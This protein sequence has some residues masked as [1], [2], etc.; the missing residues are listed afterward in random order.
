MRSFLTASSKALILK[1]KSPRPP[2]T[3]VYHPRGC[4][5]NAFEPSL[6]KR[7]PTTIRIA[8]IFA[9]A[10]SG[11]A[12]GQTLVGV[13]YQDPTVIRVSPGQVVPLLV[14]GLQTVLPSGAVN[15]D[16]VP[17]PTALAGISVTLTQPPTSYSRSLPIFSIRQF[18]HCS[19]SVAT[20]GSLAPSGDCLVTAI[21]AQIPFD[22]SVPNP[23]VASPVNNQPGTI[24]TIFENGNPSKAFVLSPVPDQI[25]V[26]QS[27]DIGGQTFE[28]GVCYPIVAHSD[29]TLVLQD[30]SAPGQVPLTNTEAHPGEVI[31]MYAY[32]LG[33]VSPAVQE[34]TTSPV[35]AAVVTAPVYLQFDYRPNA[36]PSMP[37][38][39]SP[40]TTTP[41]FVGLTP[42]EVGL[43]QLNF[44]VPPAPAGTPACGS[45]TVASLTAPILIETNLTISVMAS[46]QSFSGAAI[47][48][49][50]GSQ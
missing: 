35:P 37:T 46:G 43:Y 5:E 30:L 21:T 11:L 40:M 49:D 31:T 25:H 9:F 2:K 6:R 47:C 10:A 4:R 3:V 20:G 41:I 15:A 14:T 16:H 17:L 45:G 38:V 26:I 42:G 48:V 7:M 50:T 44:V 39:G 36:S 29:G 34:G 23:L 27:C 18:D 19:V 32:G 8:L 13:G 22:I 24:A 33:A 28:T 1:S 12:I